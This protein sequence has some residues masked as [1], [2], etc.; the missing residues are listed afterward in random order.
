LACRDIVNRPG[1]RDL[2]HAVSV[3]AEEF[4]IAH[5]DRAQPADRTDDA[6]H[7]N[8]AAGAPAHGRRVVEIDPRKGGRKTVRIA[9]AADV[10][11][12]DEVHSGALHVADREQGRKV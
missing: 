8:G 11:I 2:D 3:D 4:D 1:Q 7:N 5:L 12:G 9:F 10:A 6:R